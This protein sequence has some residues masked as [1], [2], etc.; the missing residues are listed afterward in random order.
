MNCRLLS[1]NVVIQVSRLIIKDLL[2]VPFLRKYR[3]T[4]SVPPPLSSVIGDA[5]VEA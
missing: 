5:A 1:E 3:P 2:C 4:S